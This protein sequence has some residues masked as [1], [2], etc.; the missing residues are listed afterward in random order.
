MAASSAA[1]FDLD[2]TLMAGAS[3]YHFARAAYR[4]GM[5]SRRQI[6]S[7]AYQHLRFRLR[8]S[9]DELADTLRDRILSSIE[10]RSVAQLARLAPEIMAGL[11]P[12]IYPQMLEVVRWHQDNGRPTYIATAAWQEATDLLSLILAMEGGI[13]T[14]AEIVDGVYTGKLAGPFTYGEGKAQAVREFA[15]Q[16]EIDLSASYAYS[17]SISDLPLL[18][19]VGHPVVVNPDAELRAIAREHGWEVMRFE[20]L[21]RRLI[22][23]LSVLAAAAVGGSGSWLALRKR[24][25]PT[26][27]RLRLRR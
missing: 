20:K 27:L 15:A 25:R 6:A 10:G 16:N 12:R 13:A 21:G 18:Q 5:I 17:D 3:A 7:D 22:V 14:R 4:A 11:L 8:G 9:T 26:G 19:A 1:F 23:G 24:K 2:R